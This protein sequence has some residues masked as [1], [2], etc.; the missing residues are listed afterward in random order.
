MKVNDLFVLDS[1]YNSEHNVS[2]GVGNLRFPQKYITLEW[3]G[4]LY[5]LDVVGVDSFEFIVKV[6]DRVDDGRK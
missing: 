6:V 2:S 3:D 5:N 1:V 4:V